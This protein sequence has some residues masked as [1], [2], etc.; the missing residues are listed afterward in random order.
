MKQVILDTSFILTAIKQKIDF[1]E[2]LEAMGIKI[3]I[4]EKVIKEL[5]GLESKIAL[6]IID[7]NKFKKIELKEKE[8]D[9]GIINYGKKHPDLIIATLDEEIKKKTKNRKLV[10]R[11]Q[12]KLEII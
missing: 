5:K 1:F 4:P 6:K 10:V 3:L 7:M 9:A 11:Q 2:E 12:K 8:V